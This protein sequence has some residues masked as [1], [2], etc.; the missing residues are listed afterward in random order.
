MSRNSFIVA[1]DALRRIGERLADQ[2]KRLEK[3]QQ[4]AFGTLRRRLP[5]LAGRLAT[6]TVLNVRPG[7]IRGLLSV[8]AH[9]NSALVLSGIDKRIPLKDFIGTRYAGPKAKGV[10]VKKWKDAPAEMYDA[11][12]ARSKGGLAI[13][14]AFAIKGRGVKGGVWQRIDKT[15]RDDKGRRRQVITPRTGPSFAT[16]L[17]DGKHGDIVT[18]LAD[19]AR[20][21]LQRELA[22]LTGGA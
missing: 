1:S 5:V 22:R 18:P 17:A 16:A 12:R 10:L 2:P 19:E 3:V 9:G 20:S 8:K 11:A 7:A 13:G 21:I 15:Y 6:Q 14:G 4:R